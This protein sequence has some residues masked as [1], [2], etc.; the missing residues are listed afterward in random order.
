M[1]FQAGLHF[2]ASTNCPS[3]NIYDELSGLFSPKCLKAVWRGYTLGKEYREKAED[4]FRED[5]FFAD[6]GLGV[7]TSGHKDWIEKTIKDN[8]L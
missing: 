6:Y 5:C 3:L 8:K 2:V 4:D 1:E 7:L